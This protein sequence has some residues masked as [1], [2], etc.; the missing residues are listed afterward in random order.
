MPGR[1]ADSGVPATALAV[2]WL[3]T[4]T[5]RT[6]A[7]ATRQLLADR[8]EVRARLV[9]PRQ[10][11]GAQAQVG[12]QLGAPRALPHV[13]QLRRRGVGDV[14]RGAAAEPVVDQVGQHQQGAR[15]R[16]VGRL[17]GRH[18]LVDRVERQEL[19]AGDAVQ[20]AG[21]DAAADRVH[22]AVGARRPV[23]VHGP[24]QVPERVEQAVVDGPAVDAD[25]RHR[26]VGGRLADARHDL[27]QERVEVP[28]PAAVGA[29][30]QC[31]WRTVA[32]GPARSGRRRGGR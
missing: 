30:D 17:A 24:D 31:R 6:P 27:V 25:R 13:E 20:V 9:Q 14:V 3:A 4:A 5:T 32:Q 21:A 23:R 8:P 1:E 15:R 26:P 12:Q 16:V 2:S 22:D 10:Q 18:Q 29:G 28:R 19:R 11:V 7:A